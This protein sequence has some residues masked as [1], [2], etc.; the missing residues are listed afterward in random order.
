MIGFRVIAHTP[1]CAKEIIPN[2]RSGNVTGKNSAQTKYTTPGKTASNK[3]VGNAI[4]ERRT[5][6][7]II[8]IVDKS[9]DACIENA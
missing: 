1:N 3:V 7:L 5:E 2:I 8:A 6:F 4:T 9:V